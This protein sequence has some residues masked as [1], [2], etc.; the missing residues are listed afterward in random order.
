MIDGFIVIDKPAGMSSHDVVNI[1]RRKFGQ[2]RVGH[3]GT[4]DPFATGVLVL[5]LGEAT[6]AIPFLDEAAKEYRAVMKLGEST[7][8]QD[9]T[10]EVIHRCDWRGITSDDIRRVAAGFKGKLSQLPPMFSALKHKGVPLYKLAR[11]GDEISRE[12]RQIEV[13]TLDIDNIELPEVAFT[14]SCS[15]GTY[16]RTLAHDIG[17]ELG[18]GAHLTRLQRIASGRFQ[19]KEALP[20]E[21]LD[22][23]MSDGRVEGILISPYGALDH[24][25]DLPVEESGREMVSHGIAPKLTSLAGH[26][27]TLTPG[28]LVR[29]S[30]EKRLIAV[31][32][33]AEN[34]LRL[35]RVFN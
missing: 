5:A 11:R 8:T 12:P 25:P 1:V 24:L 26:S 18:C 28:K 10:G 23:V 31:A 21:M 14:V 3:T 17:R 13:F 15:R 30:Y 29:I 9:C 27:E 33:F 19:L 6:K 22:D 20:L 34:G 16:V 7:D 32:E 35:V 2:K 4:L